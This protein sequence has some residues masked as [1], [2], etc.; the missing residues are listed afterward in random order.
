MTQRE[1]VLNHLKANPN[2][3][4]SLDAIEVYGIT[5]L[6]AVIFNL[7]AEGYS[8][9]TTEETGRNRFGEATRYAR[10]KLVQR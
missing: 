3:I 1:R 5:R 8:I 6:S 9:A 2:G 7:R 10:Y 4:T